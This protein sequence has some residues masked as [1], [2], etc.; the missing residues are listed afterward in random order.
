MAKR[1]EITIK[2]NKRPEKEDVESI[3]EWICYSLGL[4]KGRDLER[5]SAK[6]MLCFLKH[7]YTE[8]VVIP[9][10]IAKEMNLARSTVI[11]HIKKYEKAGILIRV[12]SGYELRER[13]LTETIEEIERDVEREFSRIKE[14]SRKIDELFR[15]R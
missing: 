1:L 14:L 9:E 5:T 7:I 8:G 6:M 4:V 3:M 15:K 13:T 10:V 11:H 12:G 2:A